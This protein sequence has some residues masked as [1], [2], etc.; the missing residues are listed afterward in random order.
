MKKVVNRLLLAESGPQ[1]SLK[2]TNMDVRFTRES[3]HLAN[4]EQKVR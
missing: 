2:L 1:I 4:M 3:G